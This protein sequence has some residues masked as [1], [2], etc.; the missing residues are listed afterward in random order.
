MQR[1]CLGVFRQ[2]TVV[3]TALLVACQPK[4]NPMTSEETQMVDGITANM[5]TRCVG[6][7]LIDMPERFVLNSESTTKI[8]GVDVAV[9][10]MNKWWFDKNLE[11][12]QIELSRLRFNS[13]RSEM[14]FVRSITPLLGTSVGI[15]IDRAEGP[16]TSRLSRTLELFGWRDGYQIKAF[17]NAT[18]NSFPEHANDSIA[19]RLGNDTPEKLAHLLKIYDRVS[20]RKDTEIPTTPG[21]CIPNG[22]VAGADRQGQG[23]DAVYHLADAPDVWFG[24]GS[25][26]SIKE[27]DTL[28]QRVPLVEK[29]IAESGE[30]VL[31][32]GTR[33]IHG[34][35]FEEFLMGNTPEQDGIKGSRFLM[36]GNELRVEPLQPFVH[37]GFYNGN[38]IP[39][40]E[41]SMVQKDNLRLNEILTKAT[42]SDTQALAIWDK[43]SATLRPR[44]AAY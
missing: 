24:F 26:D 10:P 40:P 13:G 32:K 17:I 18:D 19:K 9:L 42:L 28:L 14:P 15:L 21:L 34:Q 2:I 23:T 29:A 25:S 30:K 7:Y 27:K 12:K 11:G 41:L 37:L 6:R 39:V 1:I 35:K 22:F 20:G 38:R 8:E 33:N 31:R 5:T 44:P 3:L 16:D 4:A 43:V 36:H